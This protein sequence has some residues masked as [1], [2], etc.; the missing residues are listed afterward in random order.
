MRKQIFR[1]AQELYRFK[2]LSVPTTHHLDGASQIQAIK[3]MIRVSGLSSG[4]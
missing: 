4:L 1:E 2:K 3:F